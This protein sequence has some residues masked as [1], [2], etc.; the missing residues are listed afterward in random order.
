MTQPEMIE[1]MC[2]AELS[3]AD[4]KAIGHR[5]GFDAQTIGSRELMQHVFLSEQGVRA[6]LASLAESEI[7]GLHLLNC[8]GD[9]V[10]LEFFERLYPDTITSDI[11]ATYTERFRGLFQQVKTQLIRHGILVFGTLPEGILAKS[12]LERRRF[13][14]PEEFGPWLPA[15]FRARALP[16]AKAENHYPNLMREKLGEILRLPGAPGAPSPRPEGLWRVA[17]GDL[18][19]GGK[20]YRAARLRAWPAAQLEAV[21]PYASK[22]RADDFRP[23]PLL[24]YALSR[25]P[26]NEW[27]AA[28]ELLP[29]WELALPGA[30]APKPQNVCAEGCKLGCLERTEH[31]GTPFYRVPRL[32]D[33]LEGAPP[34][35]FL[36]I[37]HP[38]EVQVNLNRIPLDALERVGEVSCFKVAEGNLRILPSFLKMSHAPAETLAGPVFRWLRENHPAFRSVAESIERKR[39]R[40]IVHENLLVARVGDLSLKVML[41]KKFGAPGQWAALSDDF[42][43][44]PKGLLPVMQSWLKKSGHVIKSIQ[45]KQEIPV[46]SE[47]G[48][49]D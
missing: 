36:A 39:G 30:K 26:D 35:D 41:E 20:P 48:E 8:L 27:V 5:R 22:R 44:F 21:F 15:P 23:V 40:L 17:D 10:E 38:Q 7:L 46:D 9:E 43:A 25:L 2:L 3:Q 42:V 14:F 31:E 37:H 1:E 6:A 32:T 4:I 24:R 49:H 16:A 33:P 34:G 18:L 13:R 11:F 28:N 19:F 12:V 47:A 45:A 29:L